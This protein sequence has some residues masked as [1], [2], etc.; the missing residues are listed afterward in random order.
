MHSKQMLDDGFMKTEILK[1]A[2]DWLVCT[3]L[4]KQHAAVVFKFLH[5]PKY[6]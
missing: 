2:Q 1:D 5:I 3:E 4:M 6:F